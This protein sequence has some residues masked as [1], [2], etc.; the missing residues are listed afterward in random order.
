MWWNF[1]PQGN[2]YIT[3]L[4]IVFFTLP[5]KGEV[6]QSFG[7]YSNA[8]GGSRKAENTPLA[9]KHKPKGSARSAWMPD[10]SIS[11][12]TYLAEREGFCYVCVPLEHTHTIGDTVQP[13]L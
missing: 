2:F 4:F 13:N 6:F 3:N 7:S 9:L 5:S 11:K 1:F 8:K 10:I 12:G